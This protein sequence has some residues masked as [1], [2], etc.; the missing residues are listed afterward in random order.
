MKTYRLTWVNLYIDTPHSVVKEE[1][2]ALIMRQKLPS[3]LHNI[4]LADI[5]HHMSAYYRYQGL[6]QRFRAVAYENASRM[7]YGLKDDISTYATNIK[8]LD[9]LHGIGESIAEKII[10][11]LKSGKIKAYEKLKK[12]VPES[13]LELMDI[14]GFGPSTVKLLHQKA[15]IHSREELLEAIEAGGL[16]GLK[17]FGTKKIENL[18]RGLKVYKEG[19]GRMLLS[20]ALEIGNNFLS[21]IKNIEGVKKA[22]LAGSVRRKKETIGDIDIVVCA[23]RKDCKKIVNKII[24]VDQVGRILASGEQKVSFLV[25]ERNVQVDIRLVSEEEYGATLFYFTG[26]KEHHIKLRSWAKSKGW[27]MNEYGVFDIKTDKKLAGKTEEDIYKLFGMQYVP[28]EL[29]EDLGEI[30]MARKHKLPR[31]VELKD[32]RGDLQMHSTWS[33]GAE[34]I[35]T[36]ATHLLK[37]FPQYE[38]I[39]VT[40]HSPSERVAGGLLPGDFKKQFT[41]IAK[42]NKKLGKDFIKKGVEV[43]ILADGSL[44]LPDDLLQKFDWVTASI[45]S[46][47]HKDNTERIIKACRNPFVHCIGHPSGRLIGKRE[48]YPL[49][50]E[51]LFESLAETNTAIE[52]NAQPDRLDLKYNLVKAAIEK[53]VVIT[54]STDAHM[55][56]QFDFMQLG[57]SVARRGWCKKENILNTQSWIAVEEF[58]K[59]KTDIK[60]KTL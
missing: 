2:V 12:E 45:H 49:D 33:D 16:K 57:V 54:I 39:V 11:Y 32:M 56:T 52:I 55:L 28:P 20:V 40:D 25:Q 1:P 26:S 24:K 41:E 47:F 46:G 5:F 8:S 15:G 13:L 14:T 27:K 29:R 60:M 48:A 31:L 43:D 58:K 34:S 38:Y 42:I 9:A 50:W 10:E 51:K 35:E 23:Q 4:A 36:I 59:K 37:T 18:M 6:Q 19:R 17:G 30:E 22:E 3:K 44:D 53:G 21:S 7:I